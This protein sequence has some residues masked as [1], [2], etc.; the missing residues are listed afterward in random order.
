[1]FRVVGMQRLGDVF[2]VRSFVVW[3]WNHSL[4]GIFVQ[5]ERECE[6]FGS[7]MGSGSSKGRIDAD[8]ALQ[9]G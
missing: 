6:W 7:K 1:M 8:T 4:S 9:P 5:T 3:V 2:L